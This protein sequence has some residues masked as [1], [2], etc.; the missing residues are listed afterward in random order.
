MTES[1]VPPSLWQ[2]EERGVRARPGC[3]LRAPGLP[4]TW[5]RRRRC[6]GGNWR[7]AGPRWGEG[8]PAWGG[9]R[10]GPWWGG[11]APG[12]ARGMASARPGSLPVGEGAGGFSLVAWR[13]RCHPRSPG[14][15]SGRRPCWSVAAS[16]ELCP[17]V[18][19][20]Y[21]DSVAVPEI[22]VASGA[23][24]KEVARE[25]SRITAEVYKHY[26]Q[27]AG[28]SLK[29]C[30]YLPWVLGSFCFVFSLILPFLPRIP[31]SYLWKYCISRWES[32]RIGGVYFIL[33][34][35]VRLPLHLRVGCG[36]L[37]WFI[38]FPVMLLVNT[39]H[40]LSSYMPSAWCSSVGRC[41]ELIWHNWCTKVTFS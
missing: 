32:P 26:L 7:L 39:S 6:G 1:S 12:A 35:L 30:I 10:R 18:R 33:K 36:E 28:S 19:G 8:V 14:P 20:V 24:W 27:W 3:L 38:L 5:T 2:L 22:N 25:T 31:L 37:G 15:G 34:W 23:P 9:G 41:R 13:G 16:S 4:A 11:L 21:L 40:V 29:Q 17:E